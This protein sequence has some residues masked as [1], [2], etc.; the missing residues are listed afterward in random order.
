MSQPHIALAGPVMTSALAEFLDADT[1][2]APA[3][4]GGTPLCTL[5]RGLLERGQPCHRLFSRSVGA[6]SRNAPRRTV[7]IAL[8]PIP[9]AASHAGR[10][11]ARAHRRY[12]TSS[13]SLGQTW[14]TPTG[15]TSMPSALWHRGTRRSSPSMTGVRP[16]CGTPRS[17][18]GLLASSC[19]SR[20]RGA[21][22]SNRSLA[23]PL[24]Q[25]RARRAAVPSPSYRTR[26]N[27]HGSRCDRG[28]RTGRARAR[29]GQQ[30]ASQPAR[31]S[32]RSSTAVPLVRQAIPDM[33]AGPRRAWVRDWRN[34]VE[35]GRRARLDRRGRLQGNAPSGGRPR[36]AR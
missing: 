10:H 29:L 8:R 2:D 31:T 1:A 35:V 12:A 19:T 34:R 22:G 5:V 33:Q 15:P 28:S 9:G 30:P 18:T 25:A 11:A 14:S 3:G 27:P 20:R 23:L 24:P 4:L 7:D 13:A 16:S 6:P 21:T 36:A 26:S 17:P 32:R